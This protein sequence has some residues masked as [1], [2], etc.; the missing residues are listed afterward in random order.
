MSRESDLRTT[1]RQTSRLHQLQLLTVETVFQA[2]RIM[3]NKRQSGKVGRC[4]HATVNLRSIHNLITF[5]LAP[6]IVQRV[7]TQSLPSIQKQ[8]RHNQPAPKTDHS[9]TCLRTRTLTPGPALPQLR[10]APSSPAPRHPSSP[11]FNASR[12]TTTSVQQPKQLRPAP[13]RQPQHRAQPLW[14]ASLV[15]SSRATE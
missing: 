14:R 10:P 6:N 7:F 12:Q 4:S 3:A 13:F 9:P 11:R 15:S 1:V 8:K 5:S 2:R